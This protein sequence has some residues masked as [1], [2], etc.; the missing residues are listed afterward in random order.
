VRCTVVLEFDDDDSTTLRRVELTRLQQE[1][2]KAE[3]GDG[4][5]SLAEG[6]LGADPA[7]LHARATSAT[8]LPL[9]RTARRTLRRLA[10]FYRGHP[11]S[12]RF[13]S[14]RVS[15]PLLCGEQFNVTAPLGQD[16]PKDT[17]LSVHSQ[18]GLNA[19]ASQLNGRSWKTL[20]YETH[21]KN[22]AIYCRHPG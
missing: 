10:S 8:G 9:S 5:L 17:G 4:G 13:L 3:P 11:R 21:A 22:S 1:I 7:A 18:V 16:F 6:K 14:K 12:V 19:A 2:A 15:S 20:N